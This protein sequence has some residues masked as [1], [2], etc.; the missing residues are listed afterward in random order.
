MRHKKEITKIGSHICTLH[1]E[2]KAEFFII[3]PIDS[4]DEKELEKQITH[5]EESSSIPF[6]HVAIR[7]NKWNEEL[8][9]WPAPPVFGKIP[10]GAGAYSTLLYITSQLI[11]TLNTRYAL[12]STKDNTLL[13][14]YSLAGLFSLWAAY[15]PDNPFCGI[16]AASP[17]AWYIGWLDYAE[18]HQPLINYA[19]LS[20]G[21][22]EE[23][24][25][26]KI[27][28]TISKDILRQEQIFK[29]KG[30]NCKMEWNEG[31][32]FQDNGVRI[33]KGFVWLMHQKN[34]DFSIL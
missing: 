4:N 7:I 12:Q 21:D 15:E 19:Y 11:P 22:K 31:N 33:A 2:E 23:R 26:T 13:G 16:V 1:S 25:K 9:P 20:L 18:N 34:T 6:I 24:T 3:Q 17:S 14:G 5:I 29:D 30:V 8:T 27:M 28:A 32:H 10:F